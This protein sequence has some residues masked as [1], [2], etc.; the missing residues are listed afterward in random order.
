MSKKNKGLTALF[1][2]GCFAVVVVAVM[3][4]LVSLKASEPGDK[5]MQGVK[6]GSVDVGGMTKD[7]ARE[8]VDAYTTSLTTRKLTVVVDKKN[9]ETTLDELG[10]SCKENDFIEKAYQ[11]G[12]DV[13]IW[14]R[15]WG[16][17]VSE[18]SDVEYKLEFAVDE[19]KVRQFVEDKCKKY[20]VKMKNSKLKLKNGKFI[21]TKSRTGRKVNEEETVTVIIDAVEKNITDR[22]ITVEAVVEKTEPKYTTKMVKKCKSL[23]GTYTT[24]YA[25]ST[26]ARAN[27]VQTAANYI[28]GTVIYPGKTFS[29]IKTI[30]DRT[31]ENGYQS[32]AEYSSGKVIDGIGGGVCQV[33]TTL[34]NAVINAELEIVER[35]PHSMVVSYVDVSRDAAISGDYKDLKFKNNTDA[36]IYIGAIASGGQ[37]T[38]RIYGEETREKNRTIKFESE[39]LETIQPGADVI[40]EDPTMPASYREVTQAAHVGY[41]AKL[42]KVIYIDGKETERV[43]VNSSSYNAEP[44]YVTVGKQSQSPEP[45]ASQKPDASKEPKST[46][47][48][49]KTKEPKV[50]KTPKPTK[51]PAT[52]TPASDATDNGGSD[53]NDFAE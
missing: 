52:K 10:Y 17:S 38:F 31:V 8:A 51:Q 4:R 2:F 3:V 49:K 27:N 37:L 21:A 34:Y 46:K 35:S 26:A 28:N 45:S 30:K 36:P 19:E 9:V 12:K 16:G 1:I 5:I 20:D 44:Q 25:S 43:E 42:W 39:I 33:S 29:T 50:T 32:A 6:I 13:S 41:K 23:L 7:D 22:E 15:F 48:P 11:V 47:K 53:A 40:T 24:S 14:K 18:A